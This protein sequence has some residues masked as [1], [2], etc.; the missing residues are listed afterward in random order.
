MS[1]T[2]WITCG[3]LSAGL[4]YHG[5]RFNVDIT[6]QMEISMTHE[7]KTRQ[8]T[9]IHERNGFSVVTNVELNAPIHSS[10]TLTYLFPAKS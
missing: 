3:C 2:D 4:S 5:A 7:D 10:R 1:S 8:F 6:D 9:A